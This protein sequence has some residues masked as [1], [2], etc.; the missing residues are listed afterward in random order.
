[1]FVVC[2]T[3]VNRA[4]QT[5]SKISGHPKTRASVLIL[6]AG[7]DSPACFRG[8]SEDSQADKVKKR[9]TLNYTVC[10]ES[11]NPVSGLH[12]SVRGVMHVY[13]CI[14]SSMFFLHVYGI[15]SNLKFGI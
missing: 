10:S 8:N 12:A 9:R 6:P 14:V 5:G 7:N 11:T 4:W 13:S 3:P 1:M 2:V 15:F